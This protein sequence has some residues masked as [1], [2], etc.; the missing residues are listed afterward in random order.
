[1]VVKTLQ[2]L[3]QIIQIAG[4]TDE[5]IMVKLFSRYTSPFF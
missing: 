1:M 2:W 4:N 3:N 5:D